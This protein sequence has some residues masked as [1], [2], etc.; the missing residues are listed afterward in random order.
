MPGQPAQPGSLLGPKLLAVLALL[1]VTAAV[2]RQALLVRAPRSA[3]ALLHQLGLGYWLTTPAAV[4]PGLQSDGHGVGMQL[5][6]WWGEVSEPL[7]G[8]VEAGSGILTG[9][10]CCC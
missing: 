4:L 9:A 2:N 3:P 10:G 7:A 1:A 5:V 6:A 8:C